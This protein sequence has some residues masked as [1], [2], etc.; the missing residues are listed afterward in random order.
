MEQGCWRGRPAERSVIADIGPD[1]SCVGLHL[2]QHRHGGIVAVKPLGG[3]HVRFDEQV[4]RL[5][6]G[7]AGTDLI[8]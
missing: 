3:K 2:G 1:A 8:G 6:H 5:Q 4:K 7:S